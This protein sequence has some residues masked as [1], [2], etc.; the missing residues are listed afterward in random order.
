MFVALVV[1]AML[2]PKS[3]LDPAMQTP[4]TFEILET[5]ATFEIFATFKIFAT[6][7]TLEIFD[8]F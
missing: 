4:T 7:A 8:I 1:H 5:L 2:K 3:H 6:F